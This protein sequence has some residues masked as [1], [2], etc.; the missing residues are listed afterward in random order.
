MTRNELEPARP[1]QNS[2]ARISI[3]ITRKGGNITTTQ[4]LW[5]VLRWPR[6]LVDETESRSENRPRTTTSVTTQ[7]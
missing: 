3:C 5:E 1:L 6:P 4:Q 2:G 7:K